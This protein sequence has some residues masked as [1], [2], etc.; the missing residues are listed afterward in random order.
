MWLGLFLPKDFD[1]FWH[2]SIPWE[3]GSQLGRPWATSVPQ[4]IKF[5]P[6]SALAG[7]SAEIR[8]LASWRHLRIKNHQSPA[9]RRRGLPLQRQPYRQTSRHKRT[10]LRTRGMAYAPSFF[11]SSLRFF[12]PPIIFPSLCSPCSRSFLDSNNLYFVIPPLVLSHSL[13]SYLIFFFL[14]SFFSVF[15]I[16]CSFCS[17]CFCIVFS[18]SYISLLL[19]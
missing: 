16:S 2:V 4:S 8:F 1:F 15:V 17:F 5:F 10:C 18:L 13:R 14:I 7:G 11:S 9:E 19:L 6:F 3:I 12:S